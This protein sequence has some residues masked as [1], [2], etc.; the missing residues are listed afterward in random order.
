MQKYLR[1]SL[2]SGCAVL[3]MALGGC[4]TSGGIY[5]SELETAAEEKGTRVKRVA[6]SDAPSADSRPEPAHP[7]GWST[8]GEIANERR[9]L[10]PVANR[11]EAMVADTIS[12]A[13]TVPVVLPKGG[14]VSVADRKLWWRQHL[15]RPL[16]GAGATKITIGDAVKR[17]IEHSH[18]IRV[19]GRI[20]SVRE[21]GID[22]AKG[23]FTP[24]A[25]A[26]VKLERRNDPANSFAQ[27]SGNKRS[28][29]EEEAVEVGVRTRT[30]TG[31][32]AS[33]S[34]R[35]SSLDT[36]L[37]EFDPREQDRSR[38]TLS[39]VQPLLR[40]GGLTYNRGII[41]VAELDA[42]VGYNE[43][44]RQS[45]GHLLE[46]VRAYWTIY[47][48]RAVYLQRKRLAE[49]TRD[50]LSKLEART[51]ID[52]DEIQITRARAALSA[53]DT[54]LLRT[55]TAIENAES[56]LRALVNDPAWAAGGGREFIPS[57]LPDATYVPVNYKS[58]LSDAV[59]SRPELL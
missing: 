40:N 11:F 26:E 58:L 52:V 45:E 25:F 17:A 27:A 51:D 41:R 34:Q 20:P 7:H 28:L 48:A 21:T 54:D 6:H 18:Q 59:N 35:Y 46:I 1:L 44:V 16:E 38:T 55:R 53:R 15:G 8:R 9:D 50:L 23:R 3:A 36:N 22:E 10:E 12:K 30:L 37:T 13:P 19:F 14:Q 2:L 39:I 49:L 33:V 47:R 57:E 56:R 32:E 24:E 4:A 29:R 31:A 5:M 43:F 42:E